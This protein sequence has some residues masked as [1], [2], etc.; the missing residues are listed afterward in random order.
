[1]AVI[2]DPLRGRQRPGPSHS[3]AEIVDVLTGLAPAT[4]TAGSG[5]PMHRAVPV[6]GWA[7]LTGAGMS[8]DSGIPDYRGPDAQPR[9]PMTIQTFLSHPA[10]R[11]RY[12][13]RSWVGWPRMLRSRPNAGHLALARLPVTG[14]ITQNVDG[15]HQSAAAAVTGAS[16]V[17]DL[18]G[19]LDRVICLD[20]RTLYDRDWVQER[21]TAANPGFVET[22]GLDTIDPE[23]APD[24][25]VE[26]EETAHFRVVDCPRCGGILKPDVVYFG[27]SVPA[28]RV[29]EANRIAEAACGLVVLGSSL[30]V[31]SGLRFV[32]TAVKE[33]KPVVI[34]TDGPTRGD[35]LADYRSVS[36][37]A[38]V[39]ELWAD[40]VGSAGAL[41]RIQD[42]NEKIRI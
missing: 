31:L 36:R 25:D 35:D 8:T 15:L 5:P 32:R 7:V 28:A 3:D 13:A 11:A 1:M 37:V 41:R 6:S 34:V 17:V 12:W 42:D 30:A 40:R 24:G 20:C 21:L 10:Q 33:G 39:V 16:P 18:H 4:S 14:I 9:R 23:T 26:L 22:A 19:S 27:D 29:A 2:V 38:D